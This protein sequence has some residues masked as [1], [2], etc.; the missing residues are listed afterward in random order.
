MFE[1][2]PCQATRC[3]IAG[4]LRLAVGS[5]DNAH[6]QVC[7][8][9]ET[10]RVHHHPRPGRYNTTQAG[11]TRRAWDSG[12]GAIEKIA[13]VTRGLACR[14]IDATGDGERAGLKSRA[15][16]CSAKFVCGTHIMTVVLASCALQST[17]PGH[18]TVTE[19]SGSEKRAV[20]VAA[21]TGSLR[22]LSHPSWH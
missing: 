6:W 1:L 2:I 4:R 16:Q 9:A 8:A 17:L 14:T 18:G 13:Q 22:L 7:V 3:A 15:P 5:G 11:T 10:A 21:L 20:T 19:V 12:A